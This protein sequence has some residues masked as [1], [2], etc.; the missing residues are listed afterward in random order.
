[1]RIDVEKRC[2]VL[3]A[4]VAGKVPKG[5]FAELTEDEPSTKSEEGGQDRRQ[6]VSFSE[7]PEDGE[8]A[9]LLPIPGSV[10][11]D[12]MMNWSCSNSM[13]TYRKPWFAS[14]FRAGQGDLLSPGWGGQ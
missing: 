9:N 13:L 8:R 12:D 5:H 3:D 11:S 4:I 2:V 7:R 6:V 1:M 10:Q 14:V